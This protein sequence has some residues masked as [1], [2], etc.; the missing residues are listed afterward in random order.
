[1]GSPVGYTGDVANITPMSFTEQIKKMKQGWLAG[2][3]LVWSCR[4]HSQEV[5]VP[6]LNKE[7]RNRH[8]P[9]LAA[10]L[11]AL[12]GGG[13]VGRKRGGAVGSC[14]VGKPLRINAILRASEQW[15]RVFY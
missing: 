10:A 12:L 7:E 11:E 6:P 2:R 15:S 8:P 9:D 3:T 5:R 14:F 1:M 4:A 13:L